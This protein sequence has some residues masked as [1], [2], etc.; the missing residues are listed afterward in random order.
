MK[1][2]LSI[3]HS[4]STPSGHPVSA[5][6]FPAIIS[7]PLFKLIRSCHPSGQKPTVV[8]NVFLNKNQSPCN[9]LSDWGSCHPR[10][11]CPSTPFSFT[12]HWLYWPHGTTGIVPPQKLCIV[13]SFTSFRGLLK[14]HLS[15][16]VPAF[17]GEKN[18]PLQNIFL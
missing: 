16:V 7:S 11:S 2:Y 14:Y 13:H 18:L 17:V 5:L 4:Y 8:Y 10:D 9:G 6:N 12:L 3:P 15:D 1:N